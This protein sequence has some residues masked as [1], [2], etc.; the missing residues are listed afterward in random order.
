MPRKYSEYWSAK[1]CAA[2]I[3]NEC[4]M[5]GISEGWSGSQEELDKL[6]EICGKFNV[7]YTDD[8]RGMWEPKTPAE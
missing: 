6:V 5:H 7:V 2:S 8:F 4:V 1:A 3:I